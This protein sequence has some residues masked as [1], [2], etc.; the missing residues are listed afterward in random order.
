MACKRTRQ[1]LREDTAMASYNTRHLNRGRGTVRLRRRVLAHH[2]A[3]HILPCCDV[4]P[5]TS[6]CMFGCFNL[7]DHQPGFRPPCTR[8]HVRGTRP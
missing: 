3:P 4:H 8:P 7:F 1:R 5:D 6:V 2:L